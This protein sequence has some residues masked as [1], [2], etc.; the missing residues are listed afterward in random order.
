MSV[1][2]VSGWRPSRCLSALG[3]YRPMGACLILPRSTPRRGPG[4]SRAESSATGTAA[5]ARPLPYVPPIEAA[6]TISHESGVSDNVTRYWT[7]STRCTPT[8]DHVRWRREPRPSLQA[9]EGGLQNFADESGLSITVSHLGRVTRKWN[10]I[11]HRVFSEITKNCR[12]KPPTSYEAI[13]RV[14]AETRTAK[15][16]RIRAKIDI[17]WGKY[18]KGKKTLEADLQTG[19]LSPRDSHGGWNY[20]IVPHDKPNAHRR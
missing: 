19:M 11:E 7:R 15:G 5:C 17:D 1:R 10:K 16:L 4:L 14:I 9:V 6:T 3:A 18:P 2:G 8:A 13:V 20:T 12:G